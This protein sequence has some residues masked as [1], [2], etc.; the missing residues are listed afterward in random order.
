MAPFSIVRDGAYLLIH[1][2][3]RLIFVRNGAGSG[4]L[5]YFAFDSALL[6]LMLFISSAPAA[7]LI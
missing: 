5:H 7:F 1:A 2:H 6:R 4:A 3:W